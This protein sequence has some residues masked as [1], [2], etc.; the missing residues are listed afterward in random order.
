MAAPTSNDAFLDGL[1]KSRV[2]DPKLVT[3]ALRGAPDFPSPMKLAVFLVKK[4]LLTKFQAEQI[5]QGR[6]NLNIG[7]Y[8]ILDLIGRGG[9]GAVYLCEHVTMRRRVAL[10]VLP[11]SKSKDP[12]VVERF[13][14]EARAVG[15]LNHPNIVQAHDVDSVGKAHYLVMEYVEGINLHDLVK[16]M[17]SLIPER[18]AY[19]IREAAE[20]LQ[21]AFEAGLIHRDIKPANL[22]L[23]RQGH[24][25]ILDMGLA[26]FFHD[27]KDNLTQKFD[28]SAVLG[29]VDYLAPEQSMDSHGVDIRADIYSLGATLYFLLTARA[30][31]ASGT[32]AQKLVSINMQEPTP[33]RTMRPEVSEEMAKVLAR[34]MA[35]QPAD[36]FQTPAEV[37]AALAPW[38][39][40]FQ[41]NPELD[42]PKT[43]SKLLLDGPSTA[44]PGANSKTEALSQTNSQLTGSKTITTEDTT[45]GISSTQVFEPTDSATASAP[46]RFHFSRRVKLLA[47]AGGAGT[48][49]LLLVCSGVLI[50]FLKPSP[51]VPE[52]E[53]VSPEPPP[54]PVVS[55]PA[56][57]AHFLLDGDVTDASGRRQDLFLNNGAFFTPG[58]VGKVLQLDGKTQF[59][60]T[61]N[62]VLDTR[63]PFSVATWVKCQDVGAGWQ[64]ILSQDGQ[65]VSGFALQKRGDNKQ[66]CLTL[67]GQDDP[68]A[69]V[70]R[71]D[72]GEPV[73]PN[74][75]YHVVAVYT[76]SGVVSQT[77]AEREVVWIDDYAP[78]GA[79]FAGNKPFPFGAAPAHPVFSGS[80][81]IKT[82]QKGT[83][84]YQFE[85][86]TPGL[87]IAAGDRLFVHVYIDPKTPPREIML[88]FNDGTWDH[89]AFWGENIIPWGNAAS[90]V[91]MGPLPTPGRWVR[92]DIEAKKIGLNPGAVINGLSL[93]QHDGTV[94]WERVGIVTHNKPLAS[95]MQ[96]KL[97]V[98][99]RLR[100]TQNVPQP[101]Q[102]I[103]PFIL[104]AG[105]HDASRAAYF[106]GQ[107]AD[108]RVYGV[109]LDDDAISKLHDEGAAVTAKE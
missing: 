62:P 48:G 12:S 106:R 4:G 103:G 83:G 30:P 89:R 66:F 21:H 15:V 88:Q 27:E 2:V 19:Y 65:R 73:V 69:P 45:D 82:M 60:A 1:A 31:F 40:Q 72:G 76:N 98:N 52:P 7:K 34:M 91:S 107:V 44:T 81:S 24:I 53:N 63:Q 3:D 105:K 23:S 8:K 51:R 42:F 54:A 86:A 57:A 13:L 80:K 36:R 49:L 85:K 102:A 25:K 39:N 32:V 92:L 75:W 29:T 28:S 93:A 90:R 55:A 101:W 74:V 18:A 35:K 50:S 22:L 59:A 37:A 58:R 26:R 104:G 70:V 38:A 108:V 94:Y 99:G 6:Y 14:R 56:L 64:S 97:Y 95:P 5:L 33:I 17:G 100:D 61:A 87:R 41:P 96:A 11:S 68:K 77:P 109:A 84:Q 46:R 20:G 43:N 47:L 10:K 71:S 16:K 9:M 67:F 78:P 79:K